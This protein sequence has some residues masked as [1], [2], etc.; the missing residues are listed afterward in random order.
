MDSSALPAQTTG[1]VEDARRPRDAVSRLP[2]HQ[3]VR[4]L[5]A[6]RSRSEPVWSRG[7]YSPTIRP[8][9]TGLPLVRLEDRAVSALVPAAFILAGIALY[10]AA[11]SL[12]SAFSRL[13]PFSAEVRSE[14]THFGAFAEVGP[15]TLRRT[16][17]LVIVAAGSPNCRFSGLVRWEVGPDRGGSSLDSRSSSPSGSVG[18]PLR[19][20]PFRPTHG[21]TGSTS[22]SAAS[23]TTSMP[24]SSSPTSSSTTGPTSGR[25]SAPS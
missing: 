1:R 9:G 18:W 8:P 4:R 20:T 12:A 15:D 22:S 11:D 16:G 21:S 6:V 7:L 5:K 17:V 10:V 14:G 13:M 2:R 3:L 23:T 24:W 25:R 19:T